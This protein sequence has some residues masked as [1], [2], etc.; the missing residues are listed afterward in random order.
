MQTDE[1]PLCLCSSGQLIQSVSKS[2]TWL[3]A[4]KT[5]GQEAQPASP[6]PW[7]QLRKGRYP[8]ASE[9]MG[10]GVPRRRAGSVRAGHTAPVLA[11]REDHPEEVTEEPGSEAEG[12]RVDLEEATRGG[13]EFLRLKRSLA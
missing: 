8:Q 10:D 7:D 4:F 11:I 2:F 6:A 9:R 5:P 12:G 1:K 13:A 3:I